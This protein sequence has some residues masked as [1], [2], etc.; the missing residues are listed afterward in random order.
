MGM[1]NKA[2]RPADGW[3]EIR[4]EKAATQADDDTRASSRIR[5]M[6]QRR[7]CIPR[8]GD[9]DREMSRFRASFSY[10][11]RIWPPVCRYSISVAAC[12]SCL[13][14]IVSVCV[15]VDFVLRATDDPLSSLRQNEATFSL[16]LSFSLSLPVCVSLSANVTPS[17]MNHEIGLNR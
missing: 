3:W 2:C 14:L 8:H 1:Q 7:Q 11:A 9:R 16:L 13:A 15:Y 5:S 6:H 12:L 10:G 4:G 17:S